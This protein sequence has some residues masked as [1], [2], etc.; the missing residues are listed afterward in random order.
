MVYI[1]L[2]NFKTGINPSLKTTFNE[3]AFTGKLLPCPL[4]FS[5][6]WIKDDADKEQDLG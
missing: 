6:S 1:R 2:P 3:N 4:L 5:R